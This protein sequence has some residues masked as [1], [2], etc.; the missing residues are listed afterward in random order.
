[1]QHHRIRIA[2]LGLLHAWALLSSPGL[3]AA[4]A[5]ET[6]PEHFPGFTLA[7]LQSSD[8]TEASGLAASRNSL[9]ILWTHNDNSNDQRLFAIGQDGI[10]RAIWTLQAS[11]SVIDPEDLDIGP[12]PVA[13]VHYIYLGDIGDNNNLRANIRILRAPEPSVAYNQF[14][15]TGSIPAD[16]ITLV[17]PDGPRDA[18]SLLVD[19]NGDIYIVAKKVTPGRVYR[20]AFPQSTTQVNVLQPVGQL[21]GWGSTQPTGGSISYDGSAIIIRGYYRISMWMR[22][23]GESVAAALARPPC[24]RPTVWEQQG[25]A[26][27]FH[28]QGIGYL[29]VSEGIA[30]PIHYFPRVLTCTSD[31]QCDDGDPCTIDTCNNFGCTHLPNFNDTDGDAIPDCFD[32]CPDSPIGQP[33]D[34]FGCPVMTDIPFGQLINALIASELNPELIERFDRNA[35]GLV[36]GIDLSI[37]IRELLNN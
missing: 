32:L 24:D 29:T 27:C 16:V 12:G 23:P 7:T 37:I 11:P 28:P 18:E 35:D 20:C 22:A 30:Q 10:V 13:G 8:I 21:N 4:G 5:G 2:S 3:P 36:N 14:G 6:C 15:V 25:E 19:V 34:E 17:F 33:V 1:M 31:E 26:L 9:G